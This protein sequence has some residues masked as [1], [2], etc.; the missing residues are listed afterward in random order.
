M[1]FYKFYKSHQKSKVSVFDLVAWKFT[2]STSPIQSPKVP[3][4]DFVAWM[5]WMD[6]QI[7]SP[8]QSPKCLSLIL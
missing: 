2:S 6:L 3:V 5:D 1:I 8:I 4:F 7:T